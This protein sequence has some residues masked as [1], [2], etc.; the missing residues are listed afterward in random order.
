MGGDYFFR[1]TKENANWGAWRTRLDVPSGEA[2][3]FLRLTN[4][5]TPTPYDYSSTQPGSDGLVLLTNQPV[6]VPSYKAGQVWYV[7][8]TA[9]PGAQWSI[10]SGNLFIT[11]LPSP[12]ADASGG[13]NTV[14]APEGMNFYRL[15]V[16]SNTIAWRLGLAGLTNNLLVHQGA[17]AFTNSASYYDWKQAGQLLLV[18]PYLKSGT[19]CFVTVAGSNTQPFTLDSRQQPIIE[20]P[21]G[22]ATNVAAIDYGYVTF[23]DQ[24][25]PFQIAWQVDL[26][27]GTGEPA[28]A[29]RQST[30]ANE[31]IS[32]AMSATANAPFE[33][34]TLVPPTLTDGSYYLTVWGT[35]PFTATL[36]NSRPVIT[37]VDYAF[38]ITNDLPS[39][40]GWRFYSV[41]NIV[42]QGGLLG[43]EL[44]LNNVAPGTEIAVRR[45]AVPGRWAYR[46]NYTQGISSA[47]TTWLDASSVNG[48]LQMPRHAADIW[49]IGVNNTNQVLGSFLLTGREI[50]RPDLA[51]G[52]DFSTNQ[53]TDHLS[54]RFQYFH[55]E[56]PTNA[57][58][59][60]LQLANVASGDPR[61]VVCRGELP[62]SLPTMLVNGT[63]W[64]PNTSTNW[65]IGAQVAYNTDWT[66]FT[67]DA[68]GAGEQGRYFF[69]SQGNP[70]Q[71]GAYYVGVINGA[72]STNEMNYD[73]VVRGIFLDGSVTDVPFSGRNAESGLTPHRV[74]LH[75]VVVPTN[76]PSWNL[77]LGLGA[78]DGF[79]VLRKDGLPNYGVTA[80][81]ASSPTNLGGCLVRKTGDEHFLLLP[82]PPDTNVI[83]GTY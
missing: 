33:T 63:T 69:A 70:L 55:I 73:L 18:P 52:T 65:P 17:P 57:L 45:N 58:G 20:F 28:I 66:G 43:W 31:Y 60:E 42:Q 41:T 22:S 74:A 56:V 54:G 35:P 21:F 64:T 53:V 62:V 81:P 30:V 7:M 23:H 51:L 1:I 11:P 71:P 67:T 77:G 61:L 5:L 48:F 46:T 39:R 40:Q 25:P 49:Y 75:R 82:N 26:L 27:A 29:V 78:G 72:A 8:V 12:A 76:A 34:F 83:P 19:E 2:D 24:V 32:T 59:L 14:F 4:L 50:P 10:Y 38:S 36:M 13:T 3:L 44:L 79:F 47:V 16:N 37:P 68:T 80:G 15:T 6:T 9:T